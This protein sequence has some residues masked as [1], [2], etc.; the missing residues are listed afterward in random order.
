MRKRM[1]FV[2]IAFLAI[3]I[4]MHDSKVAD[5]AESPKYGGVATI[6]IPSDP[7]GLYGP[8]TVT[9]V[10]YSV[11]RHVTEHLIEFDDKFNLIPRLAE[12][13]NWE[14]K[15]SLVLKLRRG[16]Q[17]TDGTPWDADAAKANL[18]F[19]KNGKFKRSDMVQF[20]TGVEAID[21]YTIRIK[22][23]RPFAPFLNNLAF[24]SMM[25]VSPKQLKSTPPAKI[26]LNPIGTGPYI[27]KEWIEGDRIVLE[28]NKDYWEKGMP[29]I[30]KLIFKIVPDRSVRTM[31]ILGQQADLVMGLS[32][33][34]VG[35]LEK[36]PGV[37]V[38][39]K[40]STSVVYIALIQTKPIFKDPR[41]GKALNYALDK[42]GMLNTLMKGHATISDSYLS[43]GVFGYSSIFTYPYDPEKAKALL[44]EAG[45]PNG[46]DMA[47]AVPKGRYLMDYEIGQYVQAAL[48]KVGVRVN[49]VTWE[50]G[51]YIAKV[52]KGPK[53]R[54]EDAFMINCGSRTGHAHFCSS[55]LFHS[56]NFS[57]KGSNRF[58]Y[59]NPEVD[60][61]IDKA[62][63]TVERDKAAELYKKI[64]QTVVVED[65]PWIFLHADN[66]ICAKKSSLQGML[67]TPDEQYLLRK[68][69]FN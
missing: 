31:M 18:D 3:C 41:V 57:P 1:G 39:S 4:G 60:N 50:W 35:A 47:L 26:A 6:I 42:K 48:A 49:L 11:I 23:D 68:A 56:S 45:Y 44:K 24:A 14:D 33:L 63:S 19:V 12:T 30:D 22:L 36:K 9:A 62:S 2:I 59:S 51:T 37:E 64:Q 46:F 21:K 65:C 55:I 38:L 28:K 25:M 17:F 61:L 16:V 67:M 66:N 27:F 34:D 20:V 5:G 13:W 43:P 40:A 32:P 7:E 52:S 15:T 53:E 29:Y 69:W 58:F 10:D 8:N 54:E